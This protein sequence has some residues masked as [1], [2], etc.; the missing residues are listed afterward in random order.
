[1]KSNRTL[2]KMIFKNPSESLDIITSFFR[3]EYS[4]A[5]IELACIPG[6]GHPDLEAS[7]KLIRELIR[8][9]GKVEV[10]KTVLDHLDAARKIARETLGA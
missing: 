9:V 3:S 1:M 6:S 10:S 8:G 7:R 2:Q 4:N 5:L